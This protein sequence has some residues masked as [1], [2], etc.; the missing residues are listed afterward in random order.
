MLDVHDSVQT[1]DTYLFELSK[2]DPSDAHAPYDR[3]DTNRQT[4][5][6]IIFLHIMIFQ[7]VTKSD[8]HFIGMFGNRYAG[9]PDDL[10][11]GDVSIQHGDEL[12][13]CAT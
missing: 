13:P 9:E 8:S 2:Q 1:E 11:I 7:S 12:L 3:P 10:A 4:C 6:D 5:R